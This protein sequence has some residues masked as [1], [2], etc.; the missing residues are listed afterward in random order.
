ME[1]QFKVLLETVQPVNHRTT[2]GDDMKE[3]TVFAIIWVAAC[4]S[5]I[6]TLN[7]CKEICHEARTQYQ[8]Q[9]ERHGVRD[10]RQADGIADLLFREEA[11]E[12][13]ISI[14][15]RASKHSKAC[16]VY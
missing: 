1:G 13:G 7:L 11:K 10:D 5:S 15:Q 9:V 3:L 16:A 4:V 14:C 2:T 12:Q 8:E 6:L